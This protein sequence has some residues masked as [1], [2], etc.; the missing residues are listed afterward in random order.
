MIACMKIVEGNT[1]TDGTDPTTDAIPLDSKLPCND[2]FTNRSEGDNFPD[3]NVIDI[4]NFR[5][6]KSE[7]KDI[8]DMLERSKESGIHEAHWKELKKIEWQLERNF[9]I[10]LSSTPA[11]MQPLRIQLSQGT[12]PNRAKTRSYAPSQ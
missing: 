8:E 4:K 7:G 12:R 9:T 11:N 3:R 10:Q 5:G 6:G 1:P 2:Y